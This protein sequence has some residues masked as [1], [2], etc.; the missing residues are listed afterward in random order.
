V[1]S[2]RSALTTMRKSPNERTIK[3]GSAQG[4]WVEPRGSEM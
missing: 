3:E 2:R 1:S 4:E